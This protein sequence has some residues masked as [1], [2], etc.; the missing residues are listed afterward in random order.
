MSIVIVDSGGANLTSIGIYLKDSYDFKV[1]S[2][3]VYTNLQL[4]H[5]ACDKIKQQ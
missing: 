2:I 4:I 5:L 1:Q 3:G